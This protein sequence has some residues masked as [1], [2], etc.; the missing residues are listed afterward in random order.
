MNITTPFIASFLLL[1]ASATQAQVCAESSSSVANHATRFQIQADGTVLDT[2]LQLQWQRCSAG[3]AWDGENCRGTAEKM[4][5]AQAEKWQRDGWRVP[6]L[7]ELSAITELHCVQ[8]AIDL[9][10]FPNTP[11]ADFWSATPFAGSRA[12]DRKYWQVQFIEGESNLGGAD[13]RAHL[14]MVRNAG[15]VRLSVRVSS[16][17]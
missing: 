5:R 1:V 2:R 17:N 4:T 13:D 10:L 16:G 3:Q 11:S 9:Q 12:K 7:H 6:D 8:P 15:P 14:R